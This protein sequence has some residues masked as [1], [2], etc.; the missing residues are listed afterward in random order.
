VAEPN[1]LSSLRRIAVLVVLGLLIVVVIADVF[2]GLVGTDTFRVDVGL[3]TLIGGIVLG[4]LG[5]E[6]VTISRKRNGE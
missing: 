6:A 3:Y 2:D 1:G 4:V 5:A